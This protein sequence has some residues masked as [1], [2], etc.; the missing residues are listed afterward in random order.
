VH[1]C[2]T[3]VSPTLRIRGVRVKGACIVGI[4]G[5]IGCG[6]SEVGRILSKLGVDVLEADEVAHE[7]IEPGGPA[8]ERVVREFG[9][10]ILDA[11]GRIER[12]RLAR[13]VFADSARRERLNDIIHPIVREI[14]RK[15]VRDRRRTGKD[16]AV[17]IPLLYEIGETGIWDAVIC[18][19]ARPEHV[20]E[21]LRRRGMRTDDIRARMAAQ[22]P[23]EKKCRL[24][25]FVI[26]NDGSLKQLEEQTISVWRQVKDKERSA[27]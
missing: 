7:C 1:R 8:Y 10:G 15:W 17:I 23:V 12:H 20:L 2:V 19:T 26:K 21:R 13:I 18:V 22:M 4:T 11:E 5:G 27:R 24:A 3:R 16:A 25:D 14:W 9:D 6:K